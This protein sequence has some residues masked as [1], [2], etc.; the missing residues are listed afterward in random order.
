MLSGPL[1]SVKENVQVLTLSLH[2]LIGN[3]PYSLTNNS[4][5]VNSEN[6]VVDQLVLPK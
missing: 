3:S 4:C 2:D 1:F 5:D 6:F